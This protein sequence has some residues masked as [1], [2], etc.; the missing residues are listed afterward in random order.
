MAI[1]TFPCAAEDE[2]WAV[3]VQAAIQGLGLYSG[4]GNVLVAVNDQNRILGV[5]AWGLQSTQ[6]LLIDLLAV[7]VDYRRQGIGRGLKLELL[8][9]AGAIDRAVVSKVHHTNYKMQNLNAQFNPE[10][11]ESDE[12]SAYFA[13]AIV[14]NWDQRVSLPMAVIPKPKPNTRAVFVPGETMGPMMVGEMSRLDYVCGHCNHVLVR[15]VQPQQFVNIVFQCGTCK[16]YNEKV[17]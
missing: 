15:D 16:R 1:A 13:T 6:F 4:E 9:K 11:E 10:T 5:A 12:S 7:H 17:D 14:P 2:P 3:E 8:R